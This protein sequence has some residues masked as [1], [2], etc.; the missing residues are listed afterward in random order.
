MMK[1]HKPTVTVHQLAALILVLFSFFMSALVSRSVFERLPHLEDE[2]AYLFQARIFARGQVVVDSPSPA[3]SYWQ[4][5]I[6]DSDATG[7][8]FGK[9]TPGWPALLA[10]GELL[11][12]AWLINAFF[13]ALTIALIYRL[14][15]EIYN[16]D[17]GVFAAMLTA[18]S[19]MALLLNGTLM[20][21]SAALFYASAFIYTYWRLERGRNAI[22]WGILAGL[23]LGLLAITRPLTTLA[24]GLPFVVWS[25]I[26]LLWHLRDVGRKEF[27]PGLGQVVRTAFKAIVPSLLPLLMLSALTLLLATAIP[28]FNLVATGDQSQNLYELVWDYDRV[29]FGPCCGR[30]G[31]T[32]EKGF[33]HARFDLSL[34]A[35]DLFGWQL[36]PI[37]PQL[38]EHLRTQSNYWPVIGFSFLLLPFGLL[39]GI[40]HQAQG[41]RAKRVRFGLFAVWSMV[42]LIWVLLPLNLQTPLLGTTQTISQLFALDPG[43][44]HEPH[45]SAMWLLLGMLWLLLPLSLFIRLRATPAVPYTWLL[46]SIVVGIVVVQMGYWIGSQRYS[47]RYYY[48]ALTAAALLSALPLAWVAQRSS[49]VAI[50][51]FVLL[52]SVVS[53]YHYST[54]R[55]M[56]LHGFNN[57]DR[58]KLVEL[59]QHR[60]NDRPVLLIVKG[61]NSG[62]NRVRWRSYGV[63]MAV[64]SPFLD[65]D[66]VV[67]RDFGRLNNRER[68][69]DQFPNREIIE[70]QAVGNDAF[71][72]ED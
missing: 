43:L 69:L 32:L 24:I 11:G 57:I 18:F 55:I 12:Q 46:L 16:P 36:Q 3:S 50:Y 14:G 70:L 40:F 4:P 19:P 10:I 25:G 53:F 7:K 54:P 21:H 30:N 29:G 68:I 63:Y 35:A 64:T 45:F 34:T 39:V 41:W 23:A 56:A 59:E 67:A 71:F 9:Y 58:Q 5:F 2:V 27:E 1:K 72:V 31:H 62:E 60:E 38:Q 47:T 44:I 52:I 42:A 17:A 28:A 33:R 49:R 15:S 37:T 51:G 26:R 20:A 48:E 66:I 22:R 61:E 13:A 8:R 6:V 65:S